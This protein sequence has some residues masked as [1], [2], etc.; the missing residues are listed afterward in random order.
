[1]DVNFVLE[2]D[3]MD[4]V[5]SEMSILQDNSAS[6]SL[7]DVELLLAVVNLSKINRQ[8]ATSSP[9]GLTT[10]GPIRGNG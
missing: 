3:K 8:K 4:L 9:I 5:E 6:N 10:I 2:W 7:T 1:M